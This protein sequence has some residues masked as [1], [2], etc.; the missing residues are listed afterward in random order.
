MADILI[1]EDKDALRQM[2]RLTLEH[3]GYQ[4]IEARDAAEAQ[5]LLDLEPARLVLTDLRMPRGSGIDVLKHSREVCPGALVIVMTAYGSIDEAV[6]AMKDGAY[7][8]LQK[9]VDTRH[10]L[11]LVERAIESIRLR[12][13]NLLLKE[14]YSRR[15]GFPRIIGDS[16]QM[17]Q[18]GKA[19]QQVAATEATVLLLG[20]SGSGKELFARAIHHLSQR[21]AGPFIAI[22]C[23]AIP[24][25]LM[26]N[27]LFGHERGAYTGA[28][29]RTLGK[30]ELAQKGTLFLDEIGEMALPLQAKLLRTLQERTISRVGGHASIPIDVRII[31]A[32]NQNLTDAI[33]E[34]RFRE[35]LYF[36]LAVFPITIPPL[37]SRPS[38]IEPLAKSFAERFSREI[39]R[40][41]ISLSAD[42]IAAL[43]AYNWPGNVRELENCIERAVILCDGKTITANDLNLTQSRPNKSTFP[44][45]SHIDYS[46]SLD[47]V[48]ERALHLVQKRKIEMALRECGFN[49]SRAAELLNISY[50]TLLTKIKD[51]Q[52]E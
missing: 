39:R 28:D 50:K 22:N 26:E 10:L 18:T 1:V 30:F 8:F 37:R 23:A 9:P 3:A 35:D 11:L 42:A 19:V 49:K 43:K 51:L 12:T 5:R 45:L 41:S 34:R 40:S 24:E 27:E 31:A 13:E 14:E 25:T 21:R 15:Y 2:L 46:G 17:K 33:A 4:I 44:D 7:D 20:E 48:S 32:T 38:D 52:I 6:Q 47:E 36:R 16:E 29:T